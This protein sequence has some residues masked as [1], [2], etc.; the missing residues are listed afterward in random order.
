MFLSVTVTV[1]EAARQGLAA[2]VTH[3]SE[4]GSF[5]GTFEGIGC[6][7]RTESPPVGP[8]SAS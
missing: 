4:C 5:K 6:W 8:T 1:S 3:C 2:V 7:T